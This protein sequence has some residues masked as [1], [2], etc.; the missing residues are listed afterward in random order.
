MKSE[1]NNIIAMAPSNQSSVQLMTIQSQDGSLHNI[2]VDTQTASKGADEKRRRNAGAS[3]RSRAKRK[4][5]E[6]E[7]SIRIAKLEQKARDSNDDAEYYRTERDYWKTIAM[8]AHP[9]RHITRPPSPRLRRA[10][11]APSRAPSSTTGYA[12][13]SY[14]DCD[15]FRPQI[16]ELSCMRICPA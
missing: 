5:K 15:F 7:A 4:E 14:A 9:D 16:T 6:R 13:V 3:A 12:V 1:R 11:V 10:L 2:E 8:Q